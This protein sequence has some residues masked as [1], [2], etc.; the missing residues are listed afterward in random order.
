MKQ[1]PLFVAAL[2]LTSAVLAASPNQAVSLFGYLPLI[3]AVVGVAVLAA[4]II[5]NRPA[6]ASDMPAEFEQGSDYLRL[7]YPQP[8]S[9][10]GS[11]EI[12]EVFSYLDPDSYQLAPLIQRWAREQNHRVELVRVPFT[13][14]EQ[15]HNYAK[16]YYTARALCTTESIHG[17]L[18]DTI[19]LSNHKPE[20]EDQLAE[21]F[22]DHGI[23]P[24][25]FRNTFNAS[26]TLTSVRKAQLLLKGYGVEAAPAIIVNGTYLVT[27]T[28][29]GS[30]TRLLETLDYLIAQKC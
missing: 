21:F 28:L 25:V 16:A 1:I 10:P 11:I 19:H 9:T 12:V 4:V 14:G 6:S 7:R 5:S 20:S 18:L 26:T 30:Q 29:S 24:A 2:A 22:N 23:D 13:L 3:A 27:E 17:T 15:H 8:T